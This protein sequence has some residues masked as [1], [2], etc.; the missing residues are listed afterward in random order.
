MSSWVSSLMYSCAICR[1][2]YLDNWLSAPKP[3]KTPLKRSKPWFNKSILRRSRAF[4]ASLRFFIT[5]SEMPSSLA[6]LTLRTLPPCTA[7]P[8]ARCFTWSPAPGWKSG[9]DLRLLRSTGQEISCRGSSPSLIS[10]KASPQRFEPRWLR[11][12]GQ[13]GDGETRVRTDLK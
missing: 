6:A 2:S 3:G 1:V 13:V 10:C 9:L 5:E 12:S 7:R 4:A 8:L 11:L